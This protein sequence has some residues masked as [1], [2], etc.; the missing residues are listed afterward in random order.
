MYPVVLFVELQRHAF[1]LLESSRGKEL[2]TRAYRD[3]QNER[4]DFRI[5]G[6]VVHLKRHLESRGTTD[7]SS[8]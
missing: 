5:R 6:V 8:R 4:Q 7:L 2:D 1:S 3:V